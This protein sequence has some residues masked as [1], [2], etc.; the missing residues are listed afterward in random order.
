[1]NATT[2]TTTSE[3][4]TVE[5]LKDAMKR[6]GALTADPILVYMKREGFDPEA[7]GLMILPESLR[8]HFG[9]WGAPRYVKFSKIIDEPLM[10]IDP[11]YQIVRLTDS[12]RRI[13]E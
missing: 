11:L 7:G 5:V 2:G 6:I 1:M 8:D 13:P 12:D 9:P 3:T 10:L 4:L